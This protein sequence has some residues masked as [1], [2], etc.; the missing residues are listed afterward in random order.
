MNS[1]SIVSS[2]YFIQVVQEGNFHVQTLTTQSQTAFQ[3]I[4]SVTNIATVT[5]ARMKKG[6]TGTDLQ[7]QVT[8]NFY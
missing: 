5:L 6:V 1:A 3:L 8:S 2:L 7:N 4:W